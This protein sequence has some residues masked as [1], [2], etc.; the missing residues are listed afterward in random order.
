MVGEA[1]GV[2]VVPLDPHITFV[3][4]QSVEYERGIADRLV[5]DLGVKRRVL[6]GDVRVEGDSRIGA[7]AQ[8]DRTGMLPAASPGCASWTA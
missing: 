8:I 3:I 7:I 1:E 4:E 6:V 2:R 5:D